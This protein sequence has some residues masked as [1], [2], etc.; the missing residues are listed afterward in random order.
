MCVCW[1]LIVL[2][3]ICLGDFLVCFFIRKWGRMLLVI[4]VS[5]SLLVSVLVLSKVLIGVGKGGLSVCRY[6]LIVVLGMVF[7]DVVL[8]CVVVSCDGVC[9]V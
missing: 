8:I 4:L 9:C 7:D 1:V 5:C 3:L 2:V 6:V